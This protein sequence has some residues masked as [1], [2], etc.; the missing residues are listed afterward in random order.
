MIIKKPHTRSLP[1][2]QIYVW[3][4]L[5]LCISILLASCSQAPT[6]PAPT[7]A[8]NSVLAW[9]HQRAI[10]I[11]TLDPNA[12]LDDLNGFQSIVGNASIVGL[13]EASHSVHEF[14]VMKQRLLELLVQRMGFTMFAMEV[15]WG[16]G[17]QVN[18][19]VMTGE[20][21]LRQIVGARFFDVQEILDVIDWIRSYN[22]DPQHTQKVHFAGFHTQGGK[23]DYD[24]IQQYLQ[25]VDPQHVDS[26]MSLYS[27]VLPELEY[28][29][30]A[31]SQSLA[32]QRQDVAQAQQVYNFLKAHQAAY[33]ARSS[34]QAFTQV[35]QEAQVLI[36]TAQW[37]VH[38]PV[39][40][41]LAIKAFQQRD[42]NMTENVEWL[43]E[44][45]PGGAK[46]VL[47]AHDWHIGMWG[48]WCCDPHNRVGEP[49]TWMGQYLRQRYGDQYLAVG[50]G[51]YQGSMNAFL[52]D[53][54]GNTI[55][56]RRQVVTIGPP[57][58]QSYNATL[59][60]VGIPQY[61]LDLR[62]ASAGSVSQWLSG[63][64]QFR[65]FDNNYSTDQN[66]FYTPLSLGEWFDVMIFFQKVSPA[67]LLFN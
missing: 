30:S 47:W 12:S 5:L 44:Y 1:V 46:M 60:A 25:T 31:S 62:H 23:N 50:F 27:G 21:N 64:H 7:F 38:D 40:D 65:V 16:L 37:W 66:M 10:P 19:Y 6:K 29:P 56:D 2:T 39:D 45:A 55:S 33:I 14:S 53:A 4:S 20:G 11:Q 13:G 61:I 57:D 67:K 49:Y 26:E 36:E 24:A 18:H 3:I 28:A 8:P 15:E 17:E 58:P 32:Q 43:H 63:P 48:R 59:N 22:A 54:N 9:I 34:P 42:N 35:L 51:F 52:V 41:P